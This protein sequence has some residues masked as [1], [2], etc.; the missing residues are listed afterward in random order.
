MPLNNHHFALLPFAALLATTGCIADDEAPAA[1]IDGIDASD[2]DDTS[3]DPSHG[4]LTDDRRGIRQTAGFDLSITKAGGDL[5]L[6]W[7]DQGVGTYEV[8]TS[9]APYFL[10]SDP[11]AVLLDT[12]MGGTSYTHVGGNDDVVRY[13]RV[14]APEA[15]EPLS[16]TVGKIVHTMEPGYTKLGMCLIS[17]V[18][19]ATELFEDMESDAQDAY[20]W[21]EHD[22]QWGGSAVDAPAPGFSFDVGDVVSVSHL[23]GQPVSPALY[24]MVGHVPVE[25]DVTIEL[26]P[27]D[28]LVT[29]M[30]LRFGDIMA[31]DL[32]AQTEH[33]ERIGYWDAATQTLA[34]YPD[35][36]DFLVPTCSPLHV[37]VS[38]SSM[39]PPAQPVATSCLEI[40]QGN[41]NTPSGDYILDLDGDGPLP[42]VTTHCDMN[43]D[44][45]GW[46]ELTLDV[47]CELNATMTAVEPAPTSG[48]DELCRPFTQ[49]D[50]GG[51]TYHYTIPFPAGFSEFMLVD[52]VA[53]ANAVETS[54]MDG[55]H[56]QQSDWSVAVGGHR[57]DVGFGAAE[58][59]GPVTSLA[60]EGVAQSCQACEFAFPAN[61]EIFTVPVV[62]EGFRIGWGETGSQ[63]EG[64]YPWWSGSIRLR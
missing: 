37:E 23:A 12:V 52:Y 48:L 1:L 46:T 8:W 13:Y 24:T 2:A 15:L 61:G 47:A 60:A 27:G 36:G 6:S 45:G 64:W 3:A 21:N 9:D 57:G 58:D 53:R 7:S 55:A 25:E 39:W 32:L 11:A 22:Q 18:D 31:S 38:A 41:P 5:D 54:D 17:E 28:N 16:T 56:F 50:G 34:W 29:V 10:P 20:M 44:G 42:A 14:V 26:L 4:A 51:H 40:Q 35:D 19:T 33:G 43:T 63:H 49:D 30:P 59:P 62:S